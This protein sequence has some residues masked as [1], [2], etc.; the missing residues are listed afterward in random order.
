MHSGKLNSVFARKY[1]TMVLAISAVDLL[2]FL[3][4]IF[5]SY[6]PTSP[7]IEAK[8]IE[9]ICKNSSSIDRCFAQEFYGLTMK[10]NISFSKQTLVELQKLNSHALYCHIIAHFISQAETTKYPDKW[11]KLLIEQNPTECLGGYIHGILE[12]HLKGQKVNSSLVGK[13]CSYK[14][15]N[16][17]I[18]CVHTFGHMIIIDQMGDINKS[19]SI[20]DLLPEN[21]DSYECYSGVFMEF[22]SR[23][24]LKQH[25]IFEDPFRFD[26]K[27]VASMRAQCSLGKP[28]RQKA[29]W[30]QM[31]TIYLAYF[32][33]D[34][35]R[36]IDACKK[37]LNS[38]FKEKCFEYIILR[39]LFNGEINNDKV[40]G[41]CDLF[42]E[43]GE[44]E[45]FCYS[46][47]VSQALYSSPSYFQNAIKLCSELSPHTK[48]I[49][50]SEAFGVYIYV[51]KIVDKKFCQSFPKENA[52]ICLGEFGN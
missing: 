15:K 45:E 24:G 37:S 21:M 33:E 28:D 23:S 32:N 9:D 22:I 26:D 47:S 46:F 48:Y 35:S 50:L 49:C 39:K 4:F 13:V 52:L 42:K 36:A 1:V 40:K 18:N 27:S 14:D 7:I 25:G 30:G 20:C 34:L 11:E 6:L 38:D 51:Q 2:L 12:T 31:G 3:F 5:L 17:Q 19:T 16:T 10:K 41:I 29:C 44:S 8:K 43:A